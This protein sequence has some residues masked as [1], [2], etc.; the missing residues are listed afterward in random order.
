MKKLHVVKPVDGRPYSNYAE[1]KDNWIT[2]L[3]SHLIIRMPAED[4]FGKDIIQPEDHFYIDRKMWNMLKF[5]SA[6]SIF[7]TEGSIEFRCFPSNLTYKALTP[8]ELESVAGKYPNWEV[9]LI[10]PDRPKAEISHI[11][12]NADLYKQVVDCMGVSPEKC[13]LHFFGT[14]KG[15]ILEAD[16]FKGFAM[17]MPLCVDIDKIDGGFYKSSE[18]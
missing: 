9:V 6:K 2:V 7:R 3:T 5:S 14:D 8:T 13:V 12:L 17:I 4:V 11:G 18:E 1:V 15:I 16:S 10:T